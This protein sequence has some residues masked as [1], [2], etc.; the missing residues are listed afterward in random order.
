MEQTAAVWEGEIVEDD[1]MIDGVTSSASATNP[2]FLYEAGIICSRQADGSVELNSSGERVI[3]LREWAFLLS[4]QRIKLRRQEIKRPDW[5]KLPWTGH[6]CYLFTRAW[7]IGR[8]K[9]QFKRDKD[10]TRMRDFSENVRQSGC[11][12]MRGQGPPNNWE[13]RHNVPMNSWHETWL[14][15]QRDLDIQEDMEWLSEAVYQF[16]QVHLDRMI[17]KNEL[18]WG[19]FCKPKYYWN[20][21]KEEYEKYLDLNMTGFDLTDPN[22]VVTPT[23]KT[24]IPEPEKH[25]SFTTTLMVM[26]IEIYQG[27]SARK[28]ATMS[29]M[30]I[31]SL[32]IL[33][34][35]ESR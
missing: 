28:F 17:R 14:N 23:P 35:R 21:V 24:V 26:A 6:L 2:W 12:W 19:D 10:Y 3:N 16:Y 27:E 32:S 29:H 34:N 8:A 18:L 11:D 15:Y 13:N 9:S 22:T 33:W 20:E 5:E 4:H 30:L 25:F 1:E 31:K 7:E